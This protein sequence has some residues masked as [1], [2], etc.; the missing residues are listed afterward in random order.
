M[1]SWRKHHGPE[2]RQSHSN[3]DSEQ[4][5]GNATAETQAKGEVFPTGGMWTYFPEKVA[6]ALGSKDG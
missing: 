6:I 5:M 1:F 4:T 3:R 2:Q